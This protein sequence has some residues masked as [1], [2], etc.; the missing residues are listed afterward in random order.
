MCGLRAEDRCRP[1]LVRRTRSPRDAACSRGL[2][3]NLAG[4][5][6]QAE[7][8]PAPQTTWRD[9]R[10]RPPKAPVFAMRAWVAQCGL[11]SHLHLAQHWLP[12]PWPSG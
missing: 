8:Q 12:P 7:G 3:S 1:F 11:W 4:G 5:V 2:L 10:G 9:Q 6:R